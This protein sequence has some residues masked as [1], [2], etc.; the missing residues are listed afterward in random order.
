MWWFSWPMGTFQG[1]NHRAPLWIP[2][3]PCTFPSYCLRLVRSCVSSPA[4]AW[5]WGVCF[6][7]CLCDHHLD[8]CFLSFLLYSL[9]NHFAFFL[10]FPIWWASIC[11]SWDAHWKPTLR[12]YPRLSR[13]SDIT[14]ITGNQGARDL[15][16]KTIQSWCS[17]W[18]TAPVCGWEK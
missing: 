10:L 12:L 5:L 13:G 1:I 9:W 14:C 15:P 4:Q 8:L 2:L 18:G 6:H 3:N 11:S 16:P 17:D 7:V